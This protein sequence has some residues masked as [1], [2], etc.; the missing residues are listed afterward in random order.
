[1]RVAY[2]HQ[3]FLLQ[4]HGG[5]SRYLCEVIPRVAAEP[6]VEARVFAVAHM[7]GHLAEMAGAPGGR[8]LVTG[9]ARP[10]LPR[11][12]ALAGRLNAALSPRWL[13]GFRPDIVHETY[14]SERTLAPRGARL[15]L[16]VYDFVHERYPAMFPGRENIAPL[17]A[18]AIARA[19]HVFCISEA[20]RRDLLE[21]FPGMEERSSVSPL[22]TSLCP[23]PGAAPVDSSGKPY[24]LFVGERGRYKNFEGLARAF[25]ASEALRREFRLLCFGGRPFTDEERRLLAELKLSEA[26]VE[27]RGGDDAALVAAYRGAACLVYPSFWEG[28]GIPL[29]EAMSLGCPV[30]SSCLGSLPEAGGNA[31]EY[32]DPHEPEAVADALGR[33]LFDGERA[34]ELRR[35][36]FEQAR[37]FSWDRCARE[38]LAVYRTLA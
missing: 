12:G 21:R 10:D 15:A 5:I 18:A 3:V 30:V 33:V 13:A 38:H 16:T 29:V 35:R 25:A 28:F 1:M 34:A 22:A 14:Y 4:R 37:K 8:R 11:V 32:F 27:Q 23:T 36:G 7:N 24:V 20:T 2:D 19:D 9:F 6:H 26:E 17:K 31:A